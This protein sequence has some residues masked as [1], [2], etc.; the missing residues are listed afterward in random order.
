V[1]VVAL[2]NKGADFLPAKRGDFFRVQLV[3][4]KGFSC[5]LKIHT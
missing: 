5:T 3:A 1:Q 2:F 4:L